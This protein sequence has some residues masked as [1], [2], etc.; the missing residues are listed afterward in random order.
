[1]SRKEKIAQPIT[2]SFRLSFGAV[3]HS[4]DAKKVVIEE[5]EVKWLPAGKPAAKRRKA[6]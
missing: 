2:E 6:G 4:K 5:R 1:M 3:G